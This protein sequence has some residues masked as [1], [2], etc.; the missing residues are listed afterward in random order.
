MPEDREQ[1]EQNVG[2]AQIQE[3][4]KISEQLDALV[5]ISRRVEGLL[6]VMIEPILK[7]S[8]STIFTASKQIRAYELSDGV[9]STREIGMMVG[10]DQK[11]ISNWWRDWEKNYGIVEK[12]GKRGQFRK[13]Y[14]FADLVA[15]YA[16]ST[17]EEEAK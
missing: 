3:F 16:V 9:K 12:H 1:K 11:T 2:E 5:E 7:T 15:M 4:A 8:L 14:S 6:R 10:V 17:P 13:R